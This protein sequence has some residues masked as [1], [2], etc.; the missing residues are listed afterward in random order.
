M[1]KKLWPMMLEALMALGAHYVPAMEAAADNAGAEHGVW[2][3]LLTALTFEPEPVSNSTLQCRVPY[4]NYASLLVEAA[5]QGF[6]TPENDQFL[7]TDLGR[8]VGNE[9][10]LAAYARMGNFEPMS[11]SQLHYLSVLLRRLVVASHT[12]PE[13]P[14]KWSLTY[15][16]RIDPGVNA[17]LLIQV[18]QYLSDLAAYRDD[19][20][21]AAWQNLDFDGPAWE[22][23]TLLWRGE[24][25]TWVDIVEQ[26]AHRGYPGE[27]YAAAL[28][29]MAARDL[30]VADAGKWKLTSAGEKLRQEVENLTDEYFYAPWDCLIPD[31]L[32]A[33]ENLLKML[34]EGLG[35]KRNINC[36]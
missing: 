26:L 35:Q 21:L 11:V 15:A 29:K 22:A 33:L 14:G 30:V 1:D 8:S 5:M 36:P 10:I 24:A 4:Q 17:P 34:T 20:H 27:V 2:G 16:R 25:E 12:S 13:P 32:Q 31:D 6:F 23:L 19:A 18:D 28:E 3:L 7:L 9:L